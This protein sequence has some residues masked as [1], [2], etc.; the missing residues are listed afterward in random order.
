MAT[1]IVTLSRIDA[2]RD[3]DPP[4]AKGSGCRTE[5]LTLPATGTLTASGETIVELLADADSW[6]A[7]GTSPDVDGTD[8]RK[9][10]AN[11][12]YTFGIAD[13]EKVKVKVAS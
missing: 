12:P 2:T 11:V 13:G 4:V 5:T 3:Y 9:I 7:I 6:V 10:K 8:V 1:L